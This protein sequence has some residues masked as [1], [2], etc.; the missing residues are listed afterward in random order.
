MQEYNTRAMS[1]S[2]VAREL[3]ISRQAVS[4]TLRRTMGKLYKLVLER[5]YED[6][7]TGAVMFLQNM[8][9]VS[10]EDDVRDFYDLFPP[11]I[12][13]QIHE[14]AIKQFGGRK[15]TYERT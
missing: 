7:P 11:R 14:D 10:E 9:N 12:Q 3:G 1:G 8:L 13:K 4:Q 6:T 5:G 15:K 2:E